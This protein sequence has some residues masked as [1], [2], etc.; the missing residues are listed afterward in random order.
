[1]NYSSLTSIVEHIT[2]DSS[3]AD[4]ADSETRTAAGEEA[5]CLGVF[6]KVLFD[7]T[8]FHALSHSY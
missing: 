3:E 2:S 4:R 7:G 1:M 8:N 6:P 5:G